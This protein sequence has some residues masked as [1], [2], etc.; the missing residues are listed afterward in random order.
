MYKKI[1]RILAVLMVIILNATSYAAVGA[2]DGSAFITKS[3]FD[4]LVN[5]FNE[6][7]D[8]YEGSLVSKIDGSIANYLA[9]M[10][11]VMLLNLTDYATSVANQGSKYVTFYN[12]PTTDAFTVSNKNN[13]GKAGSFYMKYVGN[14][15][16]PSQYTNMFRESSAGFERAFQYTDFG[17]KNYLYLLMNNET[18]SDSDSGYDGNA[19]FLQEVESYYNL[20]YIRNEAS[21]IS[22]VA[23][24]AVNSSTLQSGTNKSHTVSVPNQNKYAGTFNNVESTKVGNS[25][26]NTTATISED[27]T[28]NG[29]QSFKGAGY[30]STNKIKSQTLYAVNNANKTYFDG[31]QQTITG[32]QASNAGGKF[33]TFNNGNGNYGSYT[34]SSGFT[35]T[36]KYYWHKIFTT[37]STKLSNY[38]ASQVINKAVR[39]YNGVPLTRVYLPGEVKF[40]V[41]VTNTVGNDTYLT[42]SDE[43]FDNDNRYSTKTYTAGGK[44]YDHILYNEKI[45][46]GKS[47]EV[48][49]N[50]DYVS[51]KNNGV[52]LY[53][54]LSQETYTDK[55]VKMSMVLDTTIQETTDQ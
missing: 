44:T 33:Y 26:V 2:N 42:I 46:P 13:Y 51:D 23:G 34:A 55:T 21:G 10:S 7:M 28:S 20:I 5:T 25:T 16:A 6:Q 19:A 48:K 35:W 30:P 18:I 12:Y 27:W 22:Y 4:A 17:S 43:P 24:S 15:A 47:S 41:T 8:T 29:E 39:L 38:G 32:C 1:K 40:N 3:E 36:Y 54:R 52:V 31:D 9:G 53:Y 37:D 50:V 49:F 11:N 45:T 14:N